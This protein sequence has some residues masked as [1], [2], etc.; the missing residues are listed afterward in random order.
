MSVSYNVPVQHMQVIY[1]RD[2]SLLPDHS[3]LLLSENAGDLSHARSRITHKV[4]HFCKW[5]N[6]MGDKFIGHRFKLTVL[7]YMKVSSIIFMYFHSECHLLV[8]HASFT[9]IGGTTYIL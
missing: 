3:A 2:R 9:N 7:K 6:S 8:E 5:D 1:G 4:A